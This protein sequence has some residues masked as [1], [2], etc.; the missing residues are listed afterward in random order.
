MV[1]TDTYF[2]NGAGSAS[3]LA[4]MPQDPRAANGANIPFPRYRLTTRFSCSRLGAAAGQLAHTSF[5][6]EHQFRNNWHLS[7]AGQHYS[8]HYNQKIR[9]GSAT[10]ADF[11]QQICHDP[12]STCI[13]E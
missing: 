11:P 4:L 13:R 6:Y 2:Q 10:S 1:L 3:P 5:K 7:I 8:A 9:V 12:M